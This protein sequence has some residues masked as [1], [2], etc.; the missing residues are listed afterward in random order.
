MIKRLAIVAV[1]PIV[2]AL[3]VGTSAAATASESFQPVPGTAALFAMSCEDA[4]TCLAVG[5]AGDVGSTEGVVV[6][7]TNG[8]PGSA[9]LVPGTD[10]L[11]G[12]SCSSTTTCLAVGGS[13][14]TLP[15][16]EGTLVPIKNGTAGKVEVATASL[17][18]SSVACSGSTTCIAVGVP[19]ASLNSSGSLVLSITN[20]A[21]GTYRI[22]SVDELNAVDCLSA[23]SCLAVGDNSEGEGAAVPITNGVPGSPHAMPGTSAFT[24]NAV[25]CSDAGACD[26]VGVDEQEGGTNAGAGVVVPISNSDPGTAH[27][28]ANNAL[29][30]V[31]CV[32]A[33]TCLAVGTGSGSGIM[34]PI[35]NGVPG[36]PQGTETSDEI[37]IGATCANATTCWAVGATSSQGALASLAVPQA[38]VTY[39]ALGDSY[40]SGEGNPPFIQP[41]TGCDRSVSH[42]WPELVASMFQVKLE[43]LL[44]CSGAT[45]AALN[46]SYEGQEP[47]L[48][49]LRGLSGPTLVTV[50]MGGNDLGFV[51]VLT[52]CYIGLC[53]PRLAGVEGTLA[54]GFGAHMTAVYKEIKAAA[55]N[56][57]ILVVG[58]P[59][60]VPSN[61]LTALGHCPWFKDPG[62]VLLMRAVTSQINSVLARA[63][64]AAGVSYVS[65]LNALQ[66][67]ELCTTD[68]WVNSVGPFGGSG[69]GHPTAQGQAMIAAAVED[70]VVTNHLLPGV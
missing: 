35:T 2:A 57:H 68:S 37:L 46:N 5:Y 3:T 26:A 69:R 65:T 1:V 6:P 21:P 36:S 20:G 25:S 24:M 47:Q 40:S 51:D 63:A 32:N 33:T 13:G 54:A 38:P 39:V 14:G 23:T 18:L 17:T 10:E 62:E 31:A 56:A 27:I 16:N 28:V 58:Y 52:N 30:G 29:Y 8:K 41:N 19:A 49:A 59:Q 64:A 7:I 9:Q 15:Y 42:A 45:T 67:H 43:A 60:I 61:A 11:I 50:T 22:A 12:V 53:A 55:P 70:Y 48:K 66:G 44:A 34:L 4:S